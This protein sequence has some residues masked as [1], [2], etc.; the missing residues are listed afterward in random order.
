MACNLKKVDKTRHSKIKG[1]QNSEFY[2]VLGP[3]PITN[4]NNNH[5]T[6]ATRR[7]WLST[8]MTKLCKVDFLVRAPHTRWGET[9]AMV[10]N[11]PQLAMWG[12]ILPPLPLEPKPFP[13]WR[14]TVSLPRNTKIEYQYVVV[15]KGSIC[16]WESI[17]KEKRSRTFRT[18]VST[19]GI[20][21]DDGYLD[22]ERTTRPVVPIKPSHGP[23]KNQDLPTVLGHNDMDPVLPSDV[24]TVTV[25]ASEPPMTEPKVCRSSAMQCSSTVSNQFPLKSTGSSSSKENIGL[26]DKNGTFVCAALDDA[27]CTV[28]DLRDVISALR[29]A[30]SARARIAHRLQSCE[31]HGTPTRTSPGAKANQNHT[32]GRPENIQALSVNG[33]ENFASDDRDCD[34]PHAAI[35]AVELEVNAVLA[36]VARLRARVSAAEGFIRR[37]CHITREVDWSP[38]AIVAISMVVAIIFGLFGAALTTNDKQPLAV[39][40]AFIALILACAMAVAF[41]SSRSHNACSLTKHR[42]SFGNVPSGSRHLP[43][44]AFNGYGLYGRR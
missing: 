3:E 29:P 42:N 7:A 17:H 2:V 41:V 24:T 27:R 40:I 22:E 5:F 6:I 9:I 15:R 16:H 32:S 43:K 44:S 26:L 11:V 4:T 20:L 35:R 36:D 12:T 33:V 38:A 34:S 10:G 18:F 19:S 14:V 23:T 25:D 30:A 1:Y 28:D 21:V 39:A 8:R 13:E 37:K 31:Y